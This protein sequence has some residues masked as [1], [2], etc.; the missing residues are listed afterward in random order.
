[1]PTVLTHY[2]HYL[3]F[4]LLF[5][6]LA[7]ELALHKSRVSGAVARRLA[8]A[9]ALYGFALMLVLATGLLKIFYYGKPPAYYGHNFVFHI[10]LTVVLLVFLISLYPTIHFFRARKTA[11]DDTVTYP[12][13]VG[14]ILRLEM[15]LLLIL[16]LLGVMMARGYGYSG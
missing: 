14:V 13:P 12:G 5:A 2:F 3:G 9:D 15:A 10:K 16:P 7:V 11:P 8:R 6:G 1:M 4:A